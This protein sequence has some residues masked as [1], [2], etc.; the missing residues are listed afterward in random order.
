MAL[1][2]AVFPVYVCAEG[3]SLAWPVFLSPIVAHACR[4]FG[5]QGPSLPPSSSLMRLTLSPVKEEGK[6]HHR[7]RCKISRKDVKRQ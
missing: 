3:D 1:M 6:F 4:C 7:R 5:K 2:R